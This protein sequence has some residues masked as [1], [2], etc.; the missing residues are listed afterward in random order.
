MSGDATP[1]GP[2]DGR[3]PPAFS[4]DEYAARL[5][6]VRRAMR[7]ADLDVLVA[8]DPSNMAWLTGYDG[9]SFYTDQAV[10]VTHDDDPVWWGRHMDSMGA[11]RTVWMDD[12]HVVGYADEYVQATDRHAFQHL[13]AWLTE[14]G[15]D[16]DRV[17]VELDNYYYS[18]ACHQHLGAGLPAATLVDATNLVNW[19]RMVKSP[20][21][22]D[23]MRQAGRI[24]TRMHEVIRDRVEVGLPKHELVADIVHAGISG[25]PGPDGVAGDYPAIWPLVPSG[26]DASAAHLTFDERPLRAEEMTFFE[27]AGC[28]RRYHAPLCRSVWLGSPPDEVRRA[29]AAVRAGMEA[30]LAVARAGNRVCD[31]ANAFHAE[32]EAAGIHRTGRCGYPIGLSYPPDWGERTYSV[33][34]SDTTVLRAN[35]TMHFMTGLWVDDWGL[36]LTES[37]AIRDDGPPELLADVPRELFVKPA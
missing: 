13:A 8:V 11:L 9:W 36:E 5:E 27:I 7:D 26:A 2:D 4:D 22:L 28:V 15:H 33:R 29:E 31:M 23:Y 24:V 32:L 35:M 16:G 21:E 25:I 1:A 19:Q 20:A 6:G 3:R 10:V 18:A 37:I 34:A 14:R 12:D 30:G 17:G